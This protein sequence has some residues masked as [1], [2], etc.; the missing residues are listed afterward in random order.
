ME[1]IEVNVDKTPEVFS[2]Q[3]AFADGIEVVRDGRIML[4][5]LLQ[6]DLI[7]TGRLGGGVIWTR[8][9]I[10]QVYEWQLG[11]ESYSRLSVLTDPD[12]FYSY[13]ELTEGVVYASVPN[14][15]TYFKAITP[16]KRFLLRT[17]GVRVASD[18]TEFSLRRHQHT[19]G[20]WINTFE[21]TV[22]QICVEALD[23]VGDV[24]EQGTYDAFNDS[25]PHVF[26]DGDPLP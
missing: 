21:V 17:R 15:A 16:I 12:G 6:G 26:K 8:M 23:A 18:A 25:G 1:R 4:V 13:A 22:G 9:A 11:F 14:N 19:N 20:D 3:L 7:R 24:Y 10:G 5:E 2:G